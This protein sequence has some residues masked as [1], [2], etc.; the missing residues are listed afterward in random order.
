MACRRS[1][2]LHQCLPRTELHMN[3]ET[4]WYWP[5]R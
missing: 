5:A 3:E 4:G 1:A 2:C